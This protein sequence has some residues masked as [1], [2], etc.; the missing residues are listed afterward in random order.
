[1]SS[2]PITIVGAGLAGLTLGRSLAQKG[3]QAVIY[4]RASSSPRYNHGITLHPSTYQPLL[5]ILQLDENTFHEKVAVDAQQGGEG[6]LSSTH[7]VTHS[8]YEDSSIR[9]HRGKLELL[10]REGQDI[11][12]DH[13]L[14][15]FETFPQS[16]G[17]TASFQNG[18]RIDSHYLVGC[19]GAHSMTRQILATTM[20]LKVL[21]YVVFN[22]KRHYSRAEY[23]ERLAPH[24][25]DSV[26]IQMRKGNVLLGIALDEHTVSNHTVSYT[27]S[28]PARDGNDPLHKP[29]RATIGATDIPQEVFE[30]LEALKDIDEPFADVFNA[31]NVRNDRLLHWLMRSL[32]PDREEAQKLAGQ[33]VILVGDAVHAMPILGGEGANVAIMDGIKLAEHIA[34]R[35]L[36]DMESFSS[37]RFET[38][39]KA[40]TSSERRLDEMHTAPKPCL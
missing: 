17:V 1:M 39:K 4:E 6:H 15:E 11:Q 18:T 10:L 35:G 20:K 19:D 16:R 5:R 31:K 29:D 7:L 23:Q 37:S 2:T 12:W 40:V 24:L 28:R 9:C 8:S 3:I 36:E 14:K 21:P 26:L 25:K 38:W 32:M 33:G 27:Y 34:G 30:E 13:T 22:G